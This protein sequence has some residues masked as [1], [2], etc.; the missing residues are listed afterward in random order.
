M[1]FDAQCNRARF[2]LGNS[3]TRADEAPFDRLGNRQYLA[4]IGRPIAIAR[5]WCEKR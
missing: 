5:P 1:K 4:A 3:W 2:S